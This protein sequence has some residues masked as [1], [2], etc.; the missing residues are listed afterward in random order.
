[1]YSL[2]L[3]VLMVVSG[4]F[5]KITELSLPSDIQLCF[6]NAERDTTSVGEVIFTRCIHRI[7][8]KRQSTP[9]AKPLSD[10]AVR[11]ISGLVDMNQL[12]DLGSGKDVNGLVEKLSNHSRFKRQLPRRQPRV[13]KEYRQLSDIERRLFHR[14]LNMLK[15]DTVSVHKSFIFKKEQFMFYVSMYIFK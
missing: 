4:V 5:G 1:M 10:D 9:E 3:L 15:A 7:L 6:E 14:A 13:R 11:W 8:W 2:T 12:N